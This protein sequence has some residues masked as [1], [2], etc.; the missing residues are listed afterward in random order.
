MAILTDAQRE[1]GWARLMQELSAKRV[2]ISC[3]KTALRAAFDAADQWASD[4]QAAYNLALPQPA[5]G[6]LTTADKALMLQIVLDERY[7]NG[8]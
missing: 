4:N 8:V 6:A 7:R 5:R 2:P 1:A 3:V